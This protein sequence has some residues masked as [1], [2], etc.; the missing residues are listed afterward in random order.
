M[1]VGPR[2]GRPATGRVRLREQPWPRFPGPLQRPVVRS[3]APV[4]S[5]RA[6]R[7]GACRPPCSVSGAHDL[8]RW[9]RAPRTVPCAASFPE[10]NAPGVEAFGKV[11]PLV[12]RRHDTRL[13]LGGASHSDVGGVG[14][15]RH[16][17]D[18][19]GEVAELPSCSLHFGVRLPSA[20]SRG[21]L[22]PGGRIVGHHDGETVLVRP[23]RSPRR[24]GTASPRSGSPREARPRSRRSGRGRTATA[25]PFGVSVVPVPRSRGRGR[26]GRGAR[27]GCG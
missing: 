1:E 12:N 16:R 2:G 27:S 20:C 9:F 3:V 23:S 18:R 6:Y 26:A 21:R 25:G 8:D 7:A 22:N 17:P 5:D 19:H 14:L 10:G 11:R 4:G 13:A 24:P 15:V